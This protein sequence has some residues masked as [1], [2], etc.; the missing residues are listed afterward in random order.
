M[1]ELKLFQLPDYTSCTTTLNQQKTL[2]HFAVT[3]EPLFLISP[4][5]PSILV[6][7]SNYWWPLHCLW[8]WQCLIYLFCCA[9]EL[10]FCHRSYWCIVIF[11]RPQ[12]EGHVTWMHCGALC[13]IAGL[14]RLSQA[15]AGGRR[16][17]RLAEWCGEVR[18]RRGNK[19]MQ[20]DS[21]AAMWVLRNSSLYK[22]GRTF[23]LIL[24]LLMPLLPNTHFASFSGCISNYFTKEGWRRVRKWRESGKTKT[25]R[26]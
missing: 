19:R 10:G 15:A 26:T 16:Q 7:P 6:H 13:G 20:I 11:R 25:W 17:V 9:I 8:L 1:L 22:K 4:I 18:L 12:Q 23:Y 21:R 14:H 3:W 2:L 5:H 24:I